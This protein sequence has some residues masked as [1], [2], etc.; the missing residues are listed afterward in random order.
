MGDFQG[1][2]HEENHIIVFFYDEEKGRVRVHNPSK[3]QLGP[4]V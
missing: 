2:E 4:L 1:Y 3:R